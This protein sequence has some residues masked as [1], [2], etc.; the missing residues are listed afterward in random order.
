[1][2]VQRAAE[3]EYDPVQRQEVIGIEQRGDLLRRHDGRHFRKAPD[4]GEEH[5]D[6]LFPG[7]QPPPLALHFLQ[8]LLRDKLL[9]PLV[10][11]EFPDLCPDLVVV[12]GLRQKTVYAAVHRFDGAVQ[13]RVT[14]QDDPDDVRVDPADF[15]ERLEA[16]HPGHLEVGDHRFDILRKLPDKIDA[17]QPPLGE[18]NLVAFPVENL[19]QREADAFLIIDNQNLH[20]SLRLS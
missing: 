14:R 11:D 6:G 20:E 7:D 10:D 4:V 19:F 12:E 13:R 3:F 9:Q 2:L 5:A 17:L 16:V 18:Q 1:M 15:R 8:N